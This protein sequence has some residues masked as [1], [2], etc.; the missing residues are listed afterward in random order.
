MLPKCEI[1]GGLWR[2]QAASGV[3][4]GLGRFELR[5]RAE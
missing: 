1:G 5:A 3:W 2:A 4:R